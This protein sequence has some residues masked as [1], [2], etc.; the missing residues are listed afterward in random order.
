MRLL[1]IVIVVALLVVGVGAV[2]LAVTRGSTGAGQ[3]SQ[4]LTTAVTR[5]DVVDSAVANGSVSS[6]LSYA[7]AFGAAA[8]PIVGSSSSTGTG[9]GGSTTWRVTGVKVAVGDSVTAGQILASADPTD[10]NG[11]LATAKT[12]LRAAGYRVT[13]AQNA[14][15]DIDSSET[16]A[17]RQALIQLLDAQSQRD[18][19]ARSVADLKTSIGYAT[20]KAPATG[21]VTQ[22]NIRAGTDAPSGNAV[23]IAVAP[24]DVT[25]DF[26]ES[27]LP[28]LHVGQA[29]S[30][31]VKALAATIDGTVSEIAPS[32]SSSSG[33]VV[34]YA[35][36]V[37]L[38]NAPAAL[39]SGMSAEVSVTTARASA[40]L[41][42][43]TAALQSVADGYAVEV[44]AADG[45]PRAQLVS[46][47]L[48]TSSFSEIQAG[49]SEGDRVVVG[50]TTQ[51]QTGLPGA[52]PGGG[53]R[54]GGGGGGG[55]GGGGGGGGGGTSPGGA[56]TQP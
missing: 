7:M 16:D 50:T 33:G 54:F 20:L 17:R 5:R 18:Q 1:G 11:Q 26:T 27:D 37:D 47:G 38:T 34:S 56:P 52:F 14:Y 21:T 46:V 51:R 28:A 41:A 45:Q 35:V 43:P 49:L 3:T 25:A 6:A 4:Y 32:S 12:Q 24:L 30:V 8:V 48:I 36:T 29:A 39:R 53:V 40:V 15:D 55:S 23:V 9:S 19:A 42:V 10:L 44:L 31:T 13:S 2:G 22:L